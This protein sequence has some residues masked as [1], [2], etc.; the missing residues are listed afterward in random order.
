MPRHITLAFGKTGLGITLPDQFQYI[1]LES[2]SAPPLPDPVAEIER[3]LDDPINSVPLLELARGK[4]SAAISI[5]DITRP[6]PNS[7]VLPSVLR[8]LEAAGIHRSAIT[9]MI[10]TGLHRPATAAEITEIAGAEISRDYR[11][12][13]H[14]ARSREAHRNLGTTSTGTPVLIDERFVAADLRITLGFIEPH[15][16]AGYSGGR[17]LVA[18]GLAAQET[19]QVLHSP[20]FMREP[21]AVEGS[22]ANNPLHRE[23]TEISHMAGH[24]FMVDVALSRDRKIAAVF[25]GQPVQAHQHGVA[26]V[27]GVMLQQLGHPVDA[28]ITTGAGYPLD[29]TWYQCIKG[30]TAGA[31]IVR[32]GGRILLA[33]ACSEGCGGPEFTRLLCEHPDPKVFLAAIKDSDVTIDQWQ[34]EKLA[35]VATRLDL[36]TCLPGLSDDLRGKIWGQSFGRLEPALDA[37]FAGLPPNARIGVIPEGPYVLAKV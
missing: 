25:A 14:D 24:Q 10:A 3:A 5:C 26:F 33:G 34:L 18:P 1:V 7:T 27:A 2:K 11:I 12:E 21:A 13:N 6:V 15:L 23:L 32:D 29:M 19:I 30:I 9:I 17:K 28:V 36:F 37:F 22:I 31:H 16:M 20:R 35:M 8:R 4:S